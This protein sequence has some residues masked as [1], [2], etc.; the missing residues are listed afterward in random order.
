MDDLLAQ[1]SAIAGKIGNVLISKTSSPA[2]VAGYW[3]N[4][5]RWDGTPVASTY[6]GTSL[7]WVPTSDTDAGAPY[8]GTAPGGS[9]TKHL[10]NASANIFAAAGAPW[11]LMCCDQIGYVPITGADVTGTSERTVTMTPLDGGARYAAGVGCRAFFSTYTAPTAGGPNLTSFKYKN[12]GGSSKN[13]TT[14]VSFCATPVAA[15]VPHSGNAASRFAPFL[16]LLAGD[17]GISDIEAFT[18]SGGTAYTGTGVLILHLVRPLF[19]LPLPANGIMTER[20]F[21][22]Q[23]PSLPRII[24]GAHLLFMLFQTGATTNTSPIYITMDYAWGG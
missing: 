10:I 14:S 20:D 23:L 1:I 17:T 18:L 6:A 19:T 8:I 12:V 15:L 22:N 5:N 13:M 11:I 16:P 24:D 3:S 7:T 21:V 4:L 9:A 2:Q